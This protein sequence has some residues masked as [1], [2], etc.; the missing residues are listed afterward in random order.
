VP[1]IS[2]NT[3]NVFVFSAVAVCC[4]AGAVPAHAIPRVKSKRGW[5]WVS[6]SF[7]YLSPIAERE[8]K[9]DTY[10]VVVSYII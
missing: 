7:F 10:I 8:M 2:G 5:V 4:P 6:S 9:H 3:N 1:A